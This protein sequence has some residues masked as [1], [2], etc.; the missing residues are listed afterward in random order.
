MSKK[1][2][3]SLAVIIPAYKDLF[4]KQAIESIKRQTIM[5]FSLY[6]FNDG[7]PYNLDEVIGSSIYD[8]KI[9]NIKY[10]KYNNN[11]G[12]ECLSAAWN[13]CVL[14]TTEDYIWLFSDDDIADDNCVENFQKHLQIY[15]NYDVYR[16]NNI[17]INHNDEIISKQSNHPSVE[18]AF[19]YSISR[20]H[21]ER[22]TFL[23]DHVFSRSS[24]NR[25]GGFKNFPLGWYVDDAAWISFSRYT[26]IS[27]IPGSVVKWRSGL[28]NISSDHDKK[29][30]A[31]KAE[32]LRSYFSWLISEFNEDEKLEELKKAM[33]YHL[34]FNKEY[35]SI[36][37]R[38]KIKF[39]GKEYLP[40]RTNIITRILYFIV[41][42]IKFN[43]VAAI[44]WINSKFKTLRALFY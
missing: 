7:S 3:S 36:P 31:R 5:D 34:S 44:K 26:G 6:I 20:L 42:Y 39:L 8:S 29:T 9:K 2:S 4:I 12:K 13:R 11:L 16:F 10:I 23:P 19:A 25:E 22:R 38:D 32:A 40:V 28:I 24:F 37:L 14:E 43:I 41:I 18:S 27:T 21:Y 17:I 15:P 1:T 35:F 30:Q 33:L